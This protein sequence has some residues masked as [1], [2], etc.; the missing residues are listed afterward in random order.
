MGAVKHDDDKRSE[1]V[2]DGGCAPDAVHRDLARR[3]EPESFEEHGVGH[4]AQQVLEV[5]RTTVHEIGERFGSR[6]P[7]GTVESAVSSAS[8]T[9]SPAKGQEGNVSG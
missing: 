3:F 8:G 7:L 9:A 5:L 6:S 1:R 4:E 2:P